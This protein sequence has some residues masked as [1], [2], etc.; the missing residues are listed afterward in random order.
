VGPSP[1]R[2]VS[3][4]TNIEPCC[5]LQE[6]GRFFEKSGAK[7][8]RYAGPRASAQ[9]APMAQINESLFASFSSEKEALL[10]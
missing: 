6:R 8:F 1:S 4:E 10:P 2:G 3:R 5:F 7:N 9:P